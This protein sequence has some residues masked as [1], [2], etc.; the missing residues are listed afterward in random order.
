MIMI[1]TRKQLNDVLKYEKKLY[2]SSSFARN[3]RDTLV[4]EHNSLIWKYQKYLRKEEYF[5]NKKNI[6]LSMLFRRKKNKLGAKLGFMIPVNVFGKGLHIWHF[7]S[8]IVNSGAEIGDN[9]V[10]HGDNCIGNN[11]QNQ[12]AP[13]IGSNC[14]IGVG[15]KIIGKIEIG[16]NVKIGANAVVVSNFKDGNCTVVGVPA[17][18]KNGKRD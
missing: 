18:I 7:G 5:H 13:K 17:K 14:D 8:V 15:A 3:F 10:L 9:C 16:D 4:K 12:F 6:F 2:F 11:G 1:K